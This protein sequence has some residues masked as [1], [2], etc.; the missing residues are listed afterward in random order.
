[1]MSLLAFLILV[2]YIFS[3]FYQDSLAIIN[4]FSITYLFKRLL[5]GFI[6]FLCC[7]YFFGLCSLLFPS[8]FFE[9]FVF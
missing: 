9:G 1:M 2:I 3:L 4:L 6:D 7:F 5:F 8:C